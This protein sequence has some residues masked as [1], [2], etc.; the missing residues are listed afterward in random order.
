MASKKDMTLLG[1]IIAA[2]GVTATPYHLATENELKGLVK[3]GL[4]ETNP[5]IRDGAK[6]AVRATEEGIAAFAAANASTI[7]TTPVSDPAPANAEGTTNFMTTNSALVAGVGFVPPA[8][9]RSGRGRSIYGFDTMPVGGFVFVAATA[10]KPKPE[11]S[12]GSTVSSATAKFAEPTGE[13]K[14]VTVKTYQTGT[15]GKRVKGADGKLIVVST[16][17]EVRPVMRETRKFNVVAVKAGD[18]NGEFTAPS[19]GAV[20]YRSA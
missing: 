4:A 20:V 5:E 1:V 7:P 19:D 9:A 15:D 6:I 3:E 18:V 2:M 12:L 13:N 8:T 16:K 10:D 11:Q 17:E 14:T